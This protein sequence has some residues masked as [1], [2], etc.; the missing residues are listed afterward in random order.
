MS[1]TATFIFNNKKY[2]L[3]CR[4]YLKGEEDWGGNHGRELFGTDY[5]CRCKGAEAEI[6]LETTRR[7]LIQDAKNEAN[8]LKREEHQAK[9][10]KFIDHDAN[11]EFKAG[12]ELTQL[13]EQL[14]VVTK[15]IQALH[16]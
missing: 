7:H 1:D 13:E 16:K 8:R 2:C 14:D 9:L 6:T 11:E 15:K 4:K 12:I 3:Y 5:I 10:N